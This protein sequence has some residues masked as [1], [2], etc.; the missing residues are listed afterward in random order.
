[1]PRWNGK[2]E[3]GGTAPPL[4]GSEREPSEV[5]KKL[6]AL[7][8][9][10]GCKFVEVTWQRGSWI[11]DVTFED[12]DGARGALNELEA[13]DVRELLSVDDKEEEIRAQAP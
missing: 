10:H 1:M 3:T 5:R 11:A 6:E 9:K 7:A 12:G 2:I 13:A 4:K 8:Q